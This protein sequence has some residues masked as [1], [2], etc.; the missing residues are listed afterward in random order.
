MGY[1]NP[2]ATPNLRGVEENTNRD[3]G[4]VNPEQHG[5]PGHIGGQD[6]DPGTGASGRAGGDG[7]NAP[8]PS[9]RTGEFSAKL[10]P[11]PPDPRGVRK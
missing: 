11:P 5:T 6:H 1:E 8:G 9:G 10:A 2:G 7:I 4:P 3:K